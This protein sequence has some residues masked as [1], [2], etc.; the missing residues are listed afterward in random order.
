MKDKKSGFTVVSRLTISVVSGLNTCQ[1]SR[2]WTDG[3]PSPWTVTG[4]QTTGLLY[5]H[6]KL[7]PDDDVSI[8]TDF[9][10][11]ELKK[12]TK[13]DQLADARVKAVESRRKT[14][15]VRLEERLH[16]VKTLLG[17]IDPERIE[18]VTQAM[19]S[20]EADLRH[21]LIEQFT[22]SMRAESK[23]RAD[24]AASVKRHV[25]AV[26]EEVRAL[27]HTL[28]S[29]SSK[30]CGLPYDKASTVS[31]SSNLTTL[32]TLSSKASVS[33]K[34]LHPASAH[35]P[36]RPRDDPRLIIISK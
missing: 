12:Q 7:M 30:Q 11:Q 21:E 9:D 22:E 6:T 16:Q 17:E 34:T 35:E 36:T 25:D 27:R 14:Q 5:A 32:S 29:K 31:T 23:K 2:Q 33:G 13:S 28:T 3:S 8:I 4:R 20:Q 24:E 15:K 1:T 18:Q 10:D 19:L 26:K